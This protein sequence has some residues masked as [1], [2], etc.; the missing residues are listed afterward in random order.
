VLDSVLDSVLDALSG[1]EDVSA[2]S[3]PL[4]EPLLCRC[5]EDTEREPPAEGEVPLAVS[6]AVSRAV[7]VVAPAP[8]TR[9][10]LAVPVVDC[11]SV[12]FSLCGLD[13]DCLVP[14]CPVPLR[15]ERGVRPEPAAE[16]A[17]RAPER[18]GGMDAGVP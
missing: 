18:R 8:G 13:G 7:L 2:A 1:L 10:R 4:G 3:S 9:G 5:L 14:C 11:R 16:R 15:S 6:W 12:A 17:R